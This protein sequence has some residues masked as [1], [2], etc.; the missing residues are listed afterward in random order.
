MGAAL[1]GR[2][3]EIKSSCSWITPGAIVVGVGVNRNAAGKLCGDVDFAAAKEHREL[4][5]AG[6]RRRR[7]DDDRYTA[8]EYATSGGVAGLAG[9]SATLGPGK[10]IA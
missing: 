1:P 3:C 9:R 6:S 7:T 2:V 10:F 8:R 5:H 4:D